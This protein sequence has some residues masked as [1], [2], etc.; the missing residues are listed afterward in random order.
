MTLFLPHIAS[1]QTDQQAQRSIFRIFPFFFSPYI[2]DNTKT[3]YFSSFFHRKHNCG[4]GLGQWRIDVLAMPAQ[5]LLKLLLVFPD[6]II[7]FLYLLNCHFCLF[8]HLSWLLWK[9]GIMWN[10]SYLT[11]CLFGRK[12]GWRM[13]RSGRRD[14]IHCLERL[15]LCLLRRKSERKKNVEEKSG[16]KRK[17][18]G[19]W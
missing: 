19:V 9:K 15:R 5:L 8:G 10:L 6:A 12:D 11:L 14:K 16:E 7:Q 17:S 4:C 13:E 2:E 1:I 18:Y 3:D